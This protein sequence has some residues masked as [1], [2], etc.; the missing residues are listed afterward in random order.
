L[1]SKLLI[2][3]MGY[4]ETQKLTIGVGGTVGIPTAVLLSLENSN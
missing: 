1:I 3:G 4:G 2:K